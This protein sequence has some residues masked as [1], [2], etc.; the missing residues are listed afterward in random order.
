MRVWNVQ[1]YLADILL[2]VIAEVIYESF[3]CCRKI[4]A[5]LFFVVKMNYES[6]GDLGNKVLGS[7]CSYNEI[8]Y[9]EWMMTKSPQ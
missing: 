2:Q 8:L 3:E 5:N 6:L 1:P 4:S 7:L 9:I